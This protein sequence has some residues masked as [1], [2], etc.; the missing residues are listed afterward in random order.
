MIRCYLS[1]ITLGGI[2]SINEFEIPLVVFFE[3]NLSEVV[4]IDA[5]VL[6]SH[7]CSILHE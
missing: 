6:S 2:C 3:T 4:M 1:V 5:N 7:L